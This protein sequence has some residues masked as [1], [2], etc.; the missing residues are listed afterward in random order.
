MDLDLPTTAQVEL[1]A[2]HPSGATI[3]VAREGRPVTH[4]LLRELGV[5]VA[6]VH[7]APGGH[8]REVAGGPEPE[9]EPPITVSSSRARTTKKPAPGA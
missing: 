5:T 2:D 9:G 3:L 8:P 1:H 4:E 6:D 7:P